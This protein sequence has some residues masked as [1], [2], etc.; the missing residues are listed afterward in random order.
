MFSDGSHSRRD[1]GTSFTDQVA[2]ITSALGGMCMQAQITLTDKQGDGAIGCGSILGSVGFANAW[3]ASKHR[4]NGHC[5][6]ADRAY[7]AR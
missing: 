6:A 2:V 3:M 4:V 7:M 5:M 1:M